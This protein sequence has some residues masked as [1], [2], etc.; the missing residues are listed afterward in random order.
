MRLT[1]LGSGTA[2][3]VPDRFPAGYLVESGGS[4]LMV[5]CGPGTLRRLAQ[6]GV[7]PTELD[8]VLLTHYHTDHCADL[9]ALLF[10]LR[11]PQLAKTRPLRI[12][13]LVGVHSPQTMMRDRILT[14]L[15]VAG[16]SP[17][18]ELARKMGI[19]PKTARYHL[20][21][22]LAERRVQVVGKLKRKSGGYPAPIWSADV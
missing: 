3:P 10:A 21:R 2:V 18:L 22:L 9:A 16:P 8:A 7:S 20:G 11:S 15:Q 6:S 17:S 14:H 4:K 12:Y 19:H 13:G 5:D 1:V